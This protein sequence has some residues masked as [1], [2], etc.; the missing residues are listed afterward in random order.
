MIAPARVPPT[1]TR[2]TQISG[3]IE[4]R[5]LGVITPAQIVNQLAV[6][7][8]RDYALEAFESEGPLRESRIGRSVANGSSAIRPAGSNRGF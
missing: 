6:E 5:T 8:Q 2:A 4:A 1:P 7:L 3:V